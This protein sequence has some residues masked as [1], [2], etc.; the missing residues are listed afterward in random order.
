MGVINYEKYQNMTK[1]QIAVSLE[2][3]E[4]RMQILQEKYRTKMEEQTKLIKF[5]KAKMTKALKETKLNFI[6][7]TESEAYKIGREI[8]KS[9]TPE[10]REELK[11][12]S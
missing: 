5:L 8:E 12:R 11:K 6:P 4:K 7:Y 1:R 2:N 9:M 3:A 10:E